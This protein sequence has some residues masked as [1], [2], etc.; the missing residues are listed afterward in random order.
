MNISGI[1]P[2]QG[3]YDSVIAQEPEKEKVYKLNQVAT[4]NQDEYQ[5]KA[6]PLPV[7]DLLYVG[8][9]TTKKLYSMGITTIG[10]LAQT[11]EKILI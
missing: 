11:D 9:A 3:F 2:R 10:G 5:T 4:M 7:S 6:W 1:R 8:S